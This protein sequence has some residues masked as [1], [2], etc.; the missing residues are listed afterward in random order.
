MDSLPAGV[1][2]LSLCR[3]VDDELSGLVVVTSH[4][5]EVLQL[6]VNGA[7]ADLVSVTEHTT[8]ERSKA[9]SEDHGQVEL[10][11][12][13]DD[14]FL[15]A[16]CRFVD[17]GQEEAI[18]DRSHRHDLGRSRD[19]SS[20]VGVDTSATTSLGVVQVEALATLL[21]E[22]LGALD[23]GNHAGGARR[24]PRAACMTSMTWADDV[25]ADFVHQSN[26]AHGHAE[27]GGSLVDVVSGTPS[28]RSVNASF[29]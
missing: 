13:G 1:K 10:R 9:R 6:L 2:S 15:Q 26:G 14:A 11:R 16:Q 28:N 29:M 12:V 27:L 4:L 23:H 18:L 25:E 20:D 7:H 5:R 17:H 22:Q 21:A 8:Q 3:L 19:G 24:S